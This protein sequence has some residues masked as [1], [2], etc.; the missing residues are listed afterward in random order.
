MGKF[1]EMYV[2]KERWSLS[3][4]KQNLSGKPKDMGMNNLLLVCYVQR[5]TPLPTSKYYLGV[6]LKKFLATPLIL[7]VMQIKHV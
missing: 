2:R 5:I 6:P 3:K 4:G 7:G 1:L